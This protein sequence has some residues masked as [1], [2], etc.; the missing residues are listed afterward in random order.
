MNEDIIYEKELDLPDDWDGDIILVRDGKGDI[1]ELDI[2]DDV[3][4]G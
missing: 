3:E 4:E 1:I 2:P